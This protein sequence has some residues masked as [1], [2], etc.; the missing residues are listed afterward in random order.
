MPSDALHTYLLSILF[1][2]IDQ[3]TTPISSVAFRLLSPHKIG[4]FF[5]NHSTQSIRSRCQN[6]FPR[7]Q[8]NPILS[9]ATF[10]IRIVFLM[11]N[12]ILTYFEKMR[13]GYISAYISFNVVEQLLL[14][15][16]DFSLWIFLK[17]QLFKASI[18]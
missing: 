12:I 7:I 14:T 17:C 1:G 13:F 11:L 16:P 5:E 3:E 4:A 6:A 9:L 8:S 2:I 15:P 10:F 18:F